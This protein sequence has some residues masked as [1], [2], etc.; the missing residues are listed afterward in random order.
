MMQINMSE[1][2]SEMLSYMYHQ[3]NQ[4]KMLPDDLEEYRQ[5]I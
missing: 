4:R 3:H 2:R 1:L 5:T